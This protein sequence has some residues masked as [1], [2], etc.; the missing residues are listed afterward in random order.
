MPASLSVCR[1]V[2]LF[3]RAWIEI[4]SLCVDFCVCCVALFTRAWI[5]IGVILSPIASDALSP[6]LRGRGLKYVNQR[7]IKLH[8]VALFTR[9]WIEIVTR[10]LVIKCFMVALFTRAWIEILDEMTALDA[11]PWSPSLRGR[12][13]KCILGD[14]GTKASWS[15][16][17]RGRGLK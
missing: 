17:L 3:T 16:S 11:V 12:G 6:S 7:C 14:T 15:P 8:R 10:P 1:K 2:A 13:L 4:D 9:A 5:E